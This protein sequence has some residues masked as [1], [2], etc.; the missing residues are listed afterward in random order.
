MR[1]SRHR[2][3][4]T[5]ALVAAAVLLLAPFLLF[6]LYAFSKR[7]FY[8]QILPHEWTAEAFRRQIGDSVTTSALVTSLVIAGLV[9]IISLMVG[10]PAARV[11]GT[12]ALSG[13]RFI[14]L[15]LFL[16]TVVPPV[17]EGM[18]LNVLFL[19]LGLA[20]TVLGVVLVH[21][22]PT[23][24]YVVFSLTAFF[25]RYDLGYEQQATMLGAGRVRVLF[26]IAM[27][28]AR[29]GLVVAGLFAFLVS[30]SQYLLTLMIGGGRVFTL[31]MLLFSS[32]SGGDT[33]TIA[34]LSLLF[35]A[36]PI[37][38]I[39]VAVRYLGVGGEAGEPTV[40]L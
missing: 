30:W 27:P 5:A 39:L 26:R 38:L 14:L 3:G 18:G 11:L 29:P 13:K 10:W 22:I 31:P 25:S 20:G 4:R 9:S 12:R 16:P 7:W 23:L 36:P 2:S 17:A 6:V 15:V 19:R 32:A 34:V 21:L 8:P 28:L 33:A 40:P 1:G 35:V 37:L 24:P